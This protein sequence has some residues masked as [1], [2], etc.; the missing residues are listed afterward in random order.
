MSKFLRRCARIILASPVITCIVWIMLAAL[1]TIASILWLTIDADQDSLISQELP[2]N[3]TYKDYLRTFGDLEYLYVVIETPPSPDPAEPEGQRRAARAAER[4]K[5]MLKPHLQSGELLE[6]F[7][8]V[9]LPDLEHRFLLYEKPQQLERYID[10][11]IEAA[12][13]IIPVL[14]SGSLTNMLKKMKEA[15]ESYIAG[16]AQNSS[17][18]D[19]R[20][21]PPDLITSAAAT[22]EKLF[23]AL[24]KAAEEKQP[25]FKAVELVPGLPLEKLFLSSCFFTQKGSEP[26]SYDPTRKGFLIVQILPQKDFSSLGII[27]R[28][29]S[30]I[31]TAITELRKEFPSLDIG[32]TG[33]PVIHADEMDTT[34]RDITRATCIAFPLVAL[35][36]FLLFRSI[37]RPLIA[38]LGLALAMAVT[39][40]FVTVALGHLNLLSMVFT[41]ILIGLGIDFGIH[42]LARYVEE[43][44]SGCTPRQAAENALVRSGRGCVS[45]AVTS[46]IAFFSALFTDFAGLAELGVVAGAGIV[47]CLL[48][49]MT[50]LPAALCLLDCGGKKRKTVPPLHKLPFLN[51]GVKHWKVVITAAPALCI[52]ALP[53]ACR[54]GLQR[55]LLKLQANNLESVEYERKLINE[56]GISTWEGICIVKTREQAT[57][58]ARKLEMLPEIKS[59]QTY[60]S[61]LPPQEKLSRTHLARFAPVLDMVA[62][63]ETGT[64]VDV[65]EL[66]GVV[67]E[68]KALNDSFPQQFLPPALKQI[69]H[70]LSEAAARLGN[71]QVPRQTLQDNLTAYQNKMFHNVSVNL[72]SWKKVLD[73][74]TSSWEDLPENLK[75]RFESIPERGEYYLVRAWPSG[76]AWQF[77]VL[78]QF[79]EALRQAGNK[80]DFPV[81]T[82]GVA[83]NYYESVNVMERAFYIAFLVALGFVSILVFID[84]DTMVFALLALG[85]LVMGVL[86][87]AGAM[88]LTGLNVNLANFFA[89]PVILGI[90]IDSSFHI[91]HRF[92]ERGTTHQ[93]L[94]PGTATAVILSSLTSLIG[95]GSLMTAKHVGIATLGMLLTIGTTLCLTASLVALPAF[96]S[97][98]EKKKIIRTKS[99]K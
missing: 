77:P 13:S 12:P 28:P 78:E 55:N 32:L 70:A 51:T 59:A 60:S 82:T 64:A 74:P 38:L 18:N 75:R 57:A 24:R 47:F 37:L 22:L 87:T 66:T 83:V 86:W 96:L 45:A 63:G 35:I 90:G 33:R 88:G 54:V 4:L 48:S 41:L 20:S 99:R 80:A 34:S 29:L 10:Q 8:H 30:W 39:Y 46:A 7:Y 95:L 19:L 27:S 9:H 14:E 67:K 23:S 40:G 16:T 72:E 94:N 73:P 42:I 21:L 36:F 53:F 11:A 17:F 69:S 49:G 71:P 62:I 43:A 58:F 31:R 65:E 2:Y 50:F 92:R 68:L 61:L 85:T 3:K 79:I 52:V 97:F 81:I 25:A 98:F 84:M 76:N 26:G 6:I 5:T 91:I 44:N 93:C 89:F 15:I 1:S 56:S